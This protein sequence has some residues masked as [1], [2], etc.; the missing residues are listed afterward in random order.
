MGT[1]WIMKLMGIRY[2]MGVGLIR[3]LGRGILQLGMMPALR[4]IC[5]L[6]EL[7]MMAMLRVQFW[8]RPVAEMR[9]NSILIL[10]GVGSGRAVQ[11]IQML[12]RGILEIGI[13]PDLRFMIGWIELLILGM[14]GVDIWLGPVA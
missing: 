8:L 9:T 6:V 11:W 4:L 10:M 1:N 12:S 5:G 7:M 13:M 3:M 14:L 2:G